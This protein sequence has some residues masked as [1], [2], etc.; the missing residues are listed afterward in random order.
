M[1]RPP[2]TQ[3]HEEREADLLAS[4]N[5]LLERARRAERAYKHLKS[6]MMVDRDTLMNP[7]VGPTYYLHG[8]HISAADKIAKGKQ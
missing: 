2:W 1:A 4:G 6:A 5:A 8:I 7:T 3:S